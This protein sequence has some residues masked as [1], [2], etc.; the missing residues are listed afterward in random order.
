MNQLFTHLGGVGSRTPL[1]LSYGQ[2]YLLVAKIVAGRSRPAQVSLRVYGPEE[3]IEPR[4]PNS[5]S[6]VGPPF[7][8]DLVFDW[9]EV[10]V[11]SKTRQTIDEIRLG[12]TWSSVT[13]PWTVA[14][15]AKKEG[16]P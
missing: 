6:A 12:T 16:K 9:L 3:L 14:P 13:A 7:Q 1:P 5:W 2:T 4:E 10:H 15:G 11:N 8:N